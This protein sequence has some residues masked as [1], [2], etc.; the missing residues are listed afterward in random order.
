MGNNFSVA[1]Q[2]YGY[3][4][5]VLSTIS[6]PLQKQKCTDMVVC[7]AS[8]DQFDEL[9]VGLS[10]LLAPFFWCV[11]VVVAKLFFLVIILLFLEF[12]RTNTV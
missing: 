9:H 8:A 1:C 7:G 2:K 6:F 4:M 3:G 11:C 12:Y 10:N 5:L